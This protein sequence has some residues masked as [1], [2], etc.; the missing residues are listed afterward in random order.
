MQFNCN[1]LLLLYNTTVICTA[2]HCSEQRYSTICLTLHSFSLKLCSTTID[3]KHSA[4]HCT[5]LHSA[6]Q[7]SW[8]CTAA[9]TALQPALQSALQSTLKSALQSEMEC[10]QCNER[11]SLI[12]FYSNIY[13]ELESEGKSLNIWLNIVITTSQVYNIVSFSV[14]RLGVCRVIKKLPL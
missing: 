1:V 9:C 14:E 11:A 7:K 2:M 6:I 10:S 5:V 13:I 4:L 3:L 12:F 8:H